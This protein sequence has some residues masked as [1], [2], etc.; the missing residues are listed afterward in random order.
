MFHGTGDLMIAVRMNFMMNGGISHRTLN[1]SVGIVNPTSWITVV[2]CSKMM[3]IMFAATDLGTVA[4]TTVVNVC[5]CIGMSMR[6]GTSLGIVGNGRAN[7]LEGN[8]PIN[9][10]L[11]VMI[12]TKPGSIQHDFVTLIHCI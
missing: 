9:G 10:A 11:V 7:T 5:R 6:M 3:G 12:L 2:H 4:T 8:L 1:T